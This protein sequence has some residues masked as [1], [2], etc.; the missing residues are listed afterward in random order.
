VCRGLFS[1]ATLSRWRNCRKFVLVDAWRQLDNYADGAN[2]ED[3]VQES[4]F[5]RAM[6]N[7][8]QWSN[9]RVICRNLTT[10]CAPLFEDGSFNF[11]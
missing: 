2:V 1:R 7:T 5:Q 4:L 6:Q 10:L 3:V 11:I 8:A 9:I